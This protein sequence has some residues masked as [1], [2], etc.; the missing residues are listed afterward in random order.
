MQD[1]AHSYAHHKKAAA[2]ILS[3]SMN[4]YNACYDPVT[5]TTIGSHPSAQG[6]SLLQH[7]SSVGLHWDTGGGGISSI[8]TEWK[9][10]LGTDAFGANLIGMMK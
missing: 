9:N 6:P 2:Q 8:G 4:S 7:F 3:I 5:A 10:M 1:L